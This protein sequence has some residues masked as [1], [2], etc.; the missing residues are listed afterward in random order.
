M[1]RK[2]VVSACLGEVPAGHFSRFSTVFP[3]ISAT[4]SWRSTER[5]LGDGSKGLWRYS[6]Q[7]SDGKGSKVP[8]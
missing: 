6:E 4:R 8:E 2:G 5:V 7:S 3:E 1:F